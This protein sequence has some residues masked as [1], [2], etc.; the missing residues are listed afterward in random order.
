MNLLALIPARGGSR[1]IPHKNVKML[2]GKPLIAWTIEAAQ[3]SNRINR[4]VVSTEDENIASV[5]QS[6]GADVPFLRPMNLARDDTPGIEPAL[7]AL[8]MLPQY[9][10][11]VLLQPTSP[12]RGAEDID[13]IVRFCEAREARSAVSICKAEKHPYWMFGRDA[14]DRLQPIVDVPVPTLRQELPEAYALNG[15]LYLAHREWL[16]D[17]RGFVGTDTCGYEMPVERSADVDSQLDWQ[18]VEFLI[19]NQQIGQ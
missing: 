8:S 6:W 5:A 14:A 11:L 18:W 13:G 3:Q 19:G 16:L 2:A 12:L 4:I 9:D 15:A 10:W 7:H 1:D 17:N